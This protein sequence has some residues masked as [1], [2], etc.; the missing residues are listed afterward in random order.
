MYVSG[1]MSHNDTISQLREKSQ[2]T[3]FSI[4]ILKKQDTCHGGVGV[5][6]VKLQIDHLVD[7]SLAVAVVVLANLRIHFGGFFIVLLSKCW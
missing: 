7:Q 2:K 1:R 6:S 4:C 3:W 5:S